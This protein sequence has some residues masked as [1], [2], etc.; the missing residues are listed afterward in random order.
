M[1]RR[2]SASTDITDGR[3]ILECALMMGSANDH[4]SSPLCLALSFLSLPFALAS[5]TALPKWQ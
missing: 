5:S 3:R 2:S 4:S 1:Q